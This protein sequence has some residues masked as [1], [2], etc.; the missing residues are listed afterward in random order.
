MQ[1]RGILFDNDGTLV[2]TYD[3]ILDS[4]R[5]A[6]EHV[7]GRELS[8]EEVMRGVGTPLEAQAATFT[9]DP[10]LQTKLVEVYREHNHAIH[11]DAIKL[12][13]D[14]KEGL[15]RLSAAGLVMGVVTAKR[16]ALAWR[17]LEITGAAPYLSCLIGPD[18]CPQ[19][20]PDPAPVLM[21][22]E[23][24]GLK[25]DECLYVGDSPYD[26]QAGNAAGCPTV[27]VTWGMFAEDVLRAERPR[28][29]V[30]SFS[31]LEALVSCA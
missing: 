12:F 21:G 17:G 15:T 25:P 24:L 30:G 18:D 11:D 20:K 28:Y 22:L 5:Y 13:P 4:F 26:I 14:V 2:D 27:A 1:I 16:H 29:L 31:E 9:D 19:T 6:T 3:L 8:E 10:V 23:K 7:F